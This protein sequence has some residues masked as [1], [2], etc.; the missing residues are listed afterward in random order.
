M[1]AMG[2]LVGM[3]ALWL[4]GWLPRF[5]VSEVPNGAPF[6]PERAVWS[7]LSTSDGISVAAGY[8]AYFGLVLAVLRWWRVTDRRRSSRFS[9]FPVLAAG[10]WGLVLL[11]VWP[12]PEP[13]LGVGAVVM[14][15]AIVQLVSPWE[16]PPPPTAKRVRLRYA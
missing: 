12:W 14:A 13:P 16:Q 1:L 5:P 11:V 3:G 7:A 4:N 10:F 15:A 2:A 9:F 8:L 6:S